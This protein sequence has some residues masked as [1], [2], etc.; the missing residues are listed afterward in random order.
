[1]MSVAF[2]EYEFDYC[3]VLTSLLQGNW[4]ITLQ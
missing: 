4:K 2:V 3:I 1:M